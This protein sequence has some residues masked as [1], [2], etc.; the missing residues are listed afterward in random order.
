MML[1]PLPQPTPETLPFWQG[2]REGLLRLPRCK[3]CARFHFYPRPF[4]PH[5]GSRDLA[6]QD[7]SGRGRIYT[8]TVNHRPASEAFKAFVPYAVAVVELAE[9]PRLIGRIV[10]SPLSA[11]KIGA[12]VVARFEAV[13]EEISLIHFSIAAT[14]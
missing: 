3:A 13:T 1:Q 9:G 10:E 6:W 12:A 14:S 5:C 4:C 11:V 7:A 8:F 2:A